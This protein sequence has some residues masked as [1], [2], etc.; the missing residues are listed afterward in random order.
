MSSINLLQTNWHTFTRGFSGAFAQF[1]L[2]LIQKISGCI[3]PVCE[4]GVAKTIGSHWR[5]SV[6]LVHCVS[7]CTVLWNSVSHCDNVFAPMS[8]R[9]TPLIRLDEIGVIPMGEICGSR[10]G[11]T[12]TNLRDSWLNKRC[13]A[14]VQQINTISQNVKCSLWGSDSDSGLTAKLPLPRVSKRSDACSKCCDLCV[15]LYCLWVACPIESSA[16]T[17]CCY[18]MSWEPQTSKG[19]R[20]VGQ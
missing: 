15:V 11:D 3:F 7:V 13:V 10:R 17:L 19:L 12:D 1:T 16:E 9:W 2:L 14:E 4:A 5:P 8:P 18:V 20:D 6:I